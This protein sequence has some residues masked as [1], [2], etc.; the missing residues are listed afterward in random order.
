LNNESLHINNKNKKHG[1]H[2]VGFILS[3]LC[4]I[5]CLSIPIILAFLPSFAEL[6]HLNLWLEIILILVIF[7]I[8]FWVFVKDFKSHH[9]KMPMIIFTIGLIIIIGT[10]FIQ[11]NFQTLLS[12]IGGVFLVAAHIKNWTLHK[13]D[14][15]HDH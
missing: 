5:H 9:N 6:L 12:V 13:K 2:K 8:G 3:V 15:D 11:T 10:H 4:A 7:L 1:M 14:C